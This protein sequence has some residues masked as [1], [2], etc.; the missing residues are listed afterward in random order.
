MRWLAVCLSA[1]LFV[2]CGPDGDNMIGG[3][4]HRE[5][6]AQPDVVEADPLLGDGFRVP[7][8]GARAMPNGSL[9]VLVDGFSCGAPSRVVTEETADLV[10]VSRCPLR[11]GRHLPG[12]HRALVCSGQNQPAHWATLPSG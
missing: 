11:W 1:A 4:G 10:R 3:D 7:I 12:E 6:V 2:G 8:R 9:Q 5:E